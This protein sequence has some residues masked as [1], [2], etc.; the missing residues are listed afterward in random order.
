M[1]RAAGGEGMTGTEDYMGGGKQKFTLS[2]HNWK[3]IVPTCTSITAPAVAR[4]CLP[5]MMGSRELSSI[6][7]IIK[8]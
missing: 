3:D 7:M 4:N 6:S 5:R 2:P 1:Y 8:S